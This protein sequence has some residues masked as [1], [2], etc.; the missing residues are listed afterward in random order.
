MEL[1]QLAYFVAIVEES[2]FTRAA[3]RVHVAQPAISQQIA[4][5]ERELGHR[6]FDRSDRPIRLTPVGEAF[7]PHARAALEATAAGRDAIATLHGHLAGRLAVGTVPCPPVW[8]TTRLGDFQHRHPRV[9]LTLRTGDPEVLTQD[10]SSG[11]LDAALISLSADRLPAGPAGRHLPHMLA[12]QTVGTEPL[13]LAAAPGHPLAQSPP[14]TLADLEDQP[15][16]TLTHGT[17][18][19]AALETACAEVG[20]APRVQAETNDLNTLTD[21]LRHSRAVALLP[22]AAVARAGTFLTTIRLTRPAL[23]RPH[24]LIWNRRH[25][26]ALAEAFLR[27]VQAHDEAAPSTTAP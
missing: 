6:L 1:R 3:A 21:L 4:Q 7:L 2:S 20:F 5:L 13:V 8:L 22:E 17:G 25:V 19:R 10:V 23:H 14:A 18:L 11:A 24:V 27:H 15:F 9:R 12:S 16:L 26:T